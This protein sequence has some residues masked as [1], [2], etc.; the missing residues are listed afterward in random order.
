MEISI[1][2][3]KEV[4]SNQA[5]RAINMMLQLG[6]S[7]SEIVECLKRKDG[8]L[9]ERVNPASYALQD[10]RY[11]EFIHDEYKDSIE[12]ELIDDFGMVLEDREIYL[13]H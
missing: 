12:L 9:P 1:E 4:A 8:S 7:D 10:K 6:M 3:V 13:N 2:R 11:L 5:G